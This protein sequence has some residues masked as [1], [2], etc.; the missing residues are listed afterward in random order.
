MDLNSP[1]GRG[2]GGRRCTLDRSDLVL[3]D[4]GLGIGRMTKV[5]KLIAGVL[6]SILSKKKK[7]KKRM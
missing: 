4:H 1:G 5:I 3:L 7:K 2:G 6:T